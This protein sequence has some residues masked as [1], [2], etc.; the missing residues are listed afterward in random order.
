M[1]RQALIHRPARL[2]VDALNTIYNTTKCGITSFSNRLSSFHQ[3]INHIMHSNP[4]CILTANCV[5]GSW[6][7]W[8]SCSRLGSTCGYKWG[9]ETRRRLVQHP[10][11][12]SDRPCP[13]LRESRRCRNCHKVDLIQ[14]I[15]FKQYVTDHPHSLG[16]PQV[17]FTVREDHHCCLIPLVYASSVLH[18][19]GLSE[20]LSYLQ[21]REKD[22]PSTRCL[23][24]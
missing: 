18:N 22:A 6:D 2:V 5:V 17:M 8:S 3:Q 7:S 1:T 16:S 24:R 9:F 14:Q 10:E 11:S 21:K 4:Q 23:R 20:K 15:H 13:A 19:S 12:Q